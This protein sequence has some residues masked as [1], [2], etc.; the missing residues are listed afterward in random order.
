MTTRQKWI[1]AG[2]TLAQDKNAVVACPACDVGVL[3]V[4][5]EEVN[6]GKPLN[7]EILIDRYMKCDQCGT[8]NVLSRLRI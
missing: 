4:K 1:R 7:G 8:W 2:I 6:G 3:T 5:D